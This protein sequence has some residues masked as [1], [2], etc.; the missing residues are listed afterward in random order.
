MKRSSLLLISI[1]LCASAHYA[2]S[3]E[4]ISGALYD[5]S[6]I[7]QVAFFFSEDTLYTQ[8]IDEFE[9]LA[10]YTTSGNTISLIDIFNGCDGATGSYSFV[11]DPDTLHF[12]LINDPCQER[13]EALTEMHW[14][15]ITTSIGSPPIP[16]MM[17]LYPNPSSGKIFLTT[18][19]QGPLQ[20]E[21]FDLL[22]QLV[23]EEEHK[24]NGEPIDLHAL[25]KGHYVI[26]AITP[27]GVLKGRIVLQ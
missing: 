8:D 11:I 13:V 3:L 1:L 4:N 14:V 24:G 22:G 19:H 26:K 20:I 7:Y 6:G 10:A 17:D 16:I 15:I 9:P 27:D 12:T 2:Q 25:G 21:V 18:K 5:Q 23:H